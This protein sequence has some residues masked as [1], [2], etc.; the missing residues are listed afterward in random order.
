MSYQ[1]QHLSTSHSPLHEPSPYVGCEPER[2]VH[3][4]LPV[5]RPLLH[6][7][8]GIEVEL[9]EQ[10]YRR[11]L[12]WLVD[13]FDPEYGGMVVIPVGHRLYDIQGVGDVVVVDA[14]VIDLLRIE[15]AHPVRAAYRPVLEGHETSGVRVQSGRPSEAESLA[16]IVEAVLRVFLGVHVEQDRQAEGMGPIEEGVEVVEC[17]VGASDCAVFGRAGGESERRM[18]RKEESNNVSIRFFFCACPRLGP[19]VVGWSGGRVPTLCSYAAHR[20]AR[21]VGT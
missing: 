15:L 11:Q 3:Y 1:K 9:L 12:P 14:R 4:E 6:Y 17:S 18:K 16:G 13:R 21:K 19:G 2:V 8:V 5:R 10:A 7:Q 20:K